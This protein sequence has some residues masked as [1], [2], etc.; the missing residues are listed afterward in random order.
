MQRKNTR[1]ICGFL[2]VFMGMM[3]SG[4]YAQGTSSADSRSVPIEVNL[5]VDGS[6]ALKDAGDEAVSWVSRQLVDGILQD[7]DRIT[8][9]N[10]AEKA[11]IVYSGS[12]AGADGKENIKKALRSLPKQGAQADFSGALRAAAAAVPSPK[13]AITYTLLISG[14]SS[15]SPALLGSGAS[16]MKF[17]RVEEFSGWRALVV[18]LDI[19]SRVQQAAAAWFSGS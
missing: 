15:L 4:L 2:L 13:P 12:I 5:I 1:A 16:L 8:I 9:W 17:S 18:S 14:S 6:S 11:Q 3:G 7:G 19:N 10:A